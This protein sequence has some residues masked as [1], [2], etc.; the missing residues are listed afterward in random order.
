MW[1]GWWGSTPLNINFLPRV[2][3]PGT[4]TSETGEPSILLELGW[5]GGDVDEVGDAGAAV[6]LGVGVMGF[7]VSGGGSLVG[8]GG[9]TCAVVGFVTPDV[10]VR[11]WL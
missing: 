10:G 4:G 6:A 2:A 3:K 8:E 9:T 11:V 5:G 1:F 7:G